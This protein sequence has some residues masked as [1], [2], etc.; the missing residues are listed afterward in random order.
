MGNPSWASE[1]EKL[2]KLCF[3]TGKGLGITQTFAPAK[4]ALRIYSREQI[5]EGR[6]GGGRHGPDAAHPC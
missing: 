3:Q 2:L 1:G 6:V 5:W 4:P